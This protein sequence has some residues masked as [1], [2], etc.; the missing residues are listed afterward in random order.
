MKKMECKKRAY[1]TPEIKVYPMQSDFFI[2]GSVVPDVNTSSNASWEADQEHNGGTIFL[3]DGSNVSP[4]KSWGS[5][6]E[7]GAE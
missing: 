5:V 2:C 4:A 3:G 7:D 1:T 6:W